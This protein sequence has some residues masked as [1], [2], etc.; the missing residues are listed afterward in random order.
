MQYSLAIVHS[1]PRVLSFV[2][3]TSETYAHRIRHYTTHSAT[4]RSVC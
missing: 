4:E 1:G 3:G 2:N